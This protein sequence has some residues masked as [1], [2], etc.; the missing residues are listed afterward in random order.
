MIAT[1]TLNP[2]RDRTIVIPRLAVGGLNRAGSVRDDMSGKGINVSAVLRSLGVETLCLGFIFDQGADELTETLAA[3]GLRHDFVRAPG[4]IRTNLKIF[5]AESRRMTEINEAGSPVPAERADELREKVRR[6]AR[7][8]AAVVLS[9]SAPPGVKADFYRELIEICREAN[10]SAA[11]ALDADGELL[12]N[13]LDARPDILKPNL[14]ELENLLGKKFGGGFAAERD[15]IT[16]C[17]GELARETGAGL[18]CVSMGA[19]GALLW[20]KDGVFFAKAPDVEVRSL[21]G[22]GDSMMA[23]L[24]AAYV[25]GKPPAESLRW[26][27]AAAGGSVMREGTELCGREDFDGVYGKVEIEEIRTGTI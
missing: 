18:I 12:K 22:A 23:G 16:R 25:T 6:S 5:E 14:C 10:P 27:A 11:I 21:Q 19:E 9:G 1:V 4:K 20:S 8:S 24:C 3:K 26:A 13:G 17:C 15:N 7:E 2:C